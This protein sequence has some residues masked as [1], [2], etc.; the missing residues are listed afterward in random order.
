MNLTLLAFF[1]KPG[2]AWQAVLKKAKIKLNLLTEVDML[3]MVEKSEEE[4]Y[5]TLFINI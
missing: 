1:L 2:L 3:L 4:E 5:V